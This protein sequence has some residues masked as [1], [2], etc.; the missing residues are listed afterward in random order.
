MTGGEAG[1]RV[2]TSA[3]YLVLVAGDEK[4]ETLSYTVTPNPNQQ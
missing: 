1:A 3:E 2:Y 4:G